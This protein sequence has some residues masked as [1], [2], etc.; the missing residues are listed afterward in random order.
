VVQV[1]QFH[2]SIK[3]T[4]SVR[5]DFMLP[6]TKDIPTCTPESTEVPLVAFTVRLNLVSP[7]WLNL[8]TP[9]RVAK[10]VPKIAVDKKSQFVFW[11]NH[12][13]ASRQGSD[14]PLKSITSRPQLSANQQ[15]NV[16]SFL[17]NTRH[18]AAATFWR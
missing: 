3:A 2:Y 8:V 4:R 6:N 12:V 14:I 9:G 18:E 5:F 7:K 10:A 15:F 13:R 17:P 16:G 11:E 1:Q